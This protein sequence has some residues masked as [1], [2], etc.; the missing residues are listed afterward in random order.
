MTNIGKGLPDY[1]YGITLNLEWKGLD[2]IVFGS[3][4]GG[5]EILN[6]L[7]RPGYHNSLRYF[8]LN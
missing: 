5:C 6:T 4:Q 7:Y 8:Y 3:G 2:F 1:T